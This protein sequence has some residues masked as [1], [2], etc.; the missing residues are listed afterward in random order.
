MRGGGEGGNAYRQFLAPRLN[1][2]WVVRSLWAKR[3][4]T[5]LY[6]HTQ[7]RGGGV[8]NKN[9]FLSRAPSF[10]NEMLRKPRDEK[11]GETGN[12][13]T[14]PHKGRGD[15]WRRKEIRIPVCVCVCVWHHGQR[16]KVNWLWH[17][18]FPFVAGKLFFIFLETI[19]TNEHRNSFVD[20]STFLG[21]WFLFLWKNKKLAD[22]N[23]NWST[24]VFRVFWL[25]DKWPF[26]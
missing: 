15:E 3:D 11:D 13:W 12:G 9:A 26:C 6:T 21:N 19:K 7:K 8:P 25:Y 23:S 1:D 20:L 17:K 22:S 4:V 10:F 2:R 5:T 16:H 14:V 18:F 24:K